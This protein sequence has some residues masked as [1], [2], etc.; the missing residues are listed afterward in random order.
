DLVIATHGRSFYVLDHIGLLRQAKPDTTNAPLTL[1]TP[2]D[3]MR[4]VSRGLTIDYFLK[5]AADPVTI[6]ILDGKGDVIRSFKST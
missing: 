5:D 1:F 4:S 2:A 3:A 6:E